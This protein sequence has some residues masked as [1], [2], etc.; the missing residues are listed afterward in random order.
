MVYAMATA[1]R[2]RPARFVYYTNKLAPSLLGL[3]APSLLGLLALLLC[4]EGFLG[5]SDTHTPP[6]AQAGFRL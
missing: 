5:P 2:A 6:P 1:R 3:L 4:L